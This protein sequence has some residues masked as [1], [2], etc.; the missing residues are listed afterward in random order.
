M[1][2]LQYMKHTLK[3]ATAAAL[4]M[5]AVSCNTPAE[6]SLPAI[7]SDHMVLQMERD[8]NLRGGSAPRARVRVEWRGKSYAATADGEGKWKLSIPAGEAGGPFTLKIGDKTISDVLVGEVFICS[9]Q[10][11]ME[12]PVRR[13]LDVVADD[14]K[15]YS[16]TS[17]RYFAVPTACDFNGPAEDLAGGRWEVLDSERT[18][19]GWSAVCYFTARYINEAAGVPVGMVRPALGGSPIESWMQESILP[20]YALKQLSPLKD[21]AYV[22]SLKA[23]S[24]KVYTEWPKRYNALPAVKAKWSGTGLFSRGWALDGKG[25]PWYGG[26]HF[27]NTVRLSESQAA[28]ESVL[29]LGAIVD[30]D[31]VFVNGV[32]VGSTGYRYP[33]RNYTVP[34]GTLKA[35]DNL[36]EIH[37]YSYGDD[38]ASFVKDKRYSLETPGGEISLLDGWQH[39]YDKR[40]PARDKE[41]FLQWQPSVLYNAMLAPILD[42]RSAGVIWYQGESNIDNAPLY[43]ELLETMIADWRRGMSDDSLPFY[44]IELAAYQHSE[45]SDSDFGWNR[46]Q[47]EQRRTAE[48]MDGV[49]LIP[50]GDLGEWND[51]HPQDKK[52]L[53]R[54]TADE[55]LK[56]IL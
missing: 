37:L 11:N 6:V 51:I 40:M 30:A 7:F 55:I 46:V 33:P 43:G 34:A 36:I 42:Y 35:G 27:R 9:G 47:K 21:K 50:N 28:G 54:R 4:L 49:Y 1:V 39:S 24:I 8:A 19:M 29:H 32:F 2:Y 16:N 20:D 48:K 15:D 17:I 41:I 31:S 10:S 45:L 5:A 13:C 25:K 44:I 53:G 52:T 12:L 26:H 3:L 14:V 18:A 22:D 23:A 56:H 38:P